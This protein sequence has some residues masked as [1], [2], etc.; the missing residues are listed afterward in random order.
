MA[1]PMA[2]G[3][4]EIAAAFHELADLLSIDGA[5]RFRIQAYRRAGDAISI[6]GRPLS[7]MSQA[8]ITALRGLGAGTAAKVQ[9]YLSSGSMAALQRLR[10]RYPP[11]VLEMTRLPGMGPKKA[12]AVHNALGVASLEELR[13]SIAAGRLR[14]VAGFGAKAEENLA[15]ALDRY[16]TRD[17]RVPMIDALN[18]AGE[19]LAMMRALP[20]VERATYA[21]SLRRMRDTI[22]DLDI[23][24]A[25]PTPG[26]VLAAF[27][28]LPGF[29][30]GPAGSG[31]GTVAAGPTKVSVRTGAGLQVDLRV[32][33]L[34]EFGSALQ[35]FTGSQAHNVKVRQHAVRMG[36]KL[37]EYGLFRG[38][39]RIAGETEDEVYGALGMQT[40]LPTMREDRGEVELALRGELPRVVT[41]EDLRG[42][43]QSHSTYSD[44]RRTLRE[45]AFAAAERGHEYHAVTD[46]GQNL[47]VV[48]SLSLE[49]ID[50]QADEIR[51]LNEELAGRMTL[52]HGLEANIGLDGELD[53][54][55]EIL[56]RFDV[57][58]ASLHHG[59]RMERAEMTARVVKALAHP[60]V[61]IFGHPT[62][63]ML[64]RRPASD[65]D[66]EAACRA[67]AEHG[68][69]MEL[70]ASPRRLDLKDEHAVVAREA[71]C[72]FAISTDAHAINELDYLRFGVATAQRAWLGPERIITTW[73]LDRLR[74]FLAKR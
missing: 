11:G 34:Q 73:P 62:A 40:P 52:L 56:A 36:L 41:L 43:L 59:L 37:S 58:V 6:A 19:V 47:A 8:E 9:E 48:R 66:L 10:E 24:V 60:E 53:Y 12:V 15:R 32:V 25:T 67:A 61:N 29:G 35:Y 72:L 50:R 69:A 21:G 2:P 65:F 63:R 14:E 31:E 3:N 13:A 28:A 44:G 38:G 1:P 42:D 46:H 4:A 39:N 27:P 26:P 71:G 64:P 55:E 7:T 57:V 18:V 51:R 45:M 54:P 17:Q 5:D 68:V 33:A 30:G 20:G 49:D 16:S 74:S 70:N 22:G 23:L